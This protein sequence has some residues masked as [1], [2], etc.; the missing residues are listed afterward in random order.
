MKATPE[1]QISAFLANKP[2][3]VAHLCSALADRGVSI[4]AMTVLDTVDVG[5]VR[6]LVDDVEVAKALDHAGAA[7]VEVPVISVPISSRPGSF[8]SI[9]RTLHDAAINIEY[10]YATA[11]PGMDVS[12]GVFRVSDHTAALALDFEPL[13]EVAEAG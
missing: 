7:Y 11:V 3:V 9:A 10:I 12:L 6:M 8:A 1:I 13:A 4:R 5:T 2:G